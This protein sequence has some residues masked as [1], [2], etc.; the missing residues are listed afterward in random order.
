M[1]FTHSRKKNWFFLVTYSRIGHGLGFTA[2][3]EGLLWKENPSND[4]Q[5]TSYTAF[6]E[7]FW[8]IEVF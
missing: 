4:S 1:P 6:G 5:M 2:F 8:V 7:A 3:I